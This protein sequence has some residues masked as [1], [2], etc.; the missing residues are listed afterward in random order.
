V[1]TPAARFQ[2]LTRDGVV[3][4]NDPNSERAG[5]V[6]LS[7]SV[8]Q[9]A[10]YDPADPNKGLA[11]HHTPTSSVQPTTIN[12]PPPTTN[13]PPPLTSSS[14]PI[15]VPAPPPSSPS[16]TTS[17]SSPTTSTPPPVP[18][19]L[20]IAVSKNSPM[21]TEDITLKV[22]ADTGTPTTAHWD[23]GDGQ[24][25]DGVTVTHRWANIQTYQVSVQATMADGRQAT[26]SISI[27]TTPMPTPGPK[28]KVTLTVMV[29]VGVGGVATV[30][31][32]DNA[33]N[34]P[35]TCAVQVDSGQSVTLG[36]TGDG[37]TTTS[38]T[39]WNGC[40]GA[41]TVAAGTAYCTMAVVASTTVTANFTYYGLA[42]PIL[43]SPADGAVFNT[44]PRTTTFTWQPV[45]GV[46]QYYFEAEF[47]TVDLSSG[48]VTW[49]APYQTATVTGTTYT[50]N[51]VGGQPGRW[52]VTAGAP[53][54]QG[55]PSSWWTFSYT[56]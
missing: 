28:P 20:A 37:A 40:T 9:I 53:G 27:T 32:T 5:I 18:L 30:A 46:T 41:E 31:G 56:V 48:A 35:G 24:T 36:A 17:S 12:N 21:A 44:F 19:N 1:L 33:I 47:G 2:L 23:F 8:T 42:P 39:S 3:F 29:S 22:S 51:F 14:L 11:G 54:S 45:S 52:H 4:F 7:G 15:T 13:T 16:R 50:F 34:C 26:T 49:S 55:T 25:A 10:K 43:V 6:S 38:F